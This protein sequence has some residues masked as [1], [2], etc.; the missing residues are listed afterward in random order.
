MNRNAVDPK[1]A[2]PGWVGAAAALTVFWC[3]ARWGLDLAG[4][5]ANLVVIVMSLT[6]WL[7]PGLNQ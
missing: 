6:G 7:T 5:E 4:Q 1:V 3:K 2:V